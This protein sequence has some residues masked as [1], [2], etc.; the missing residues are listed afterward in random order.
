M[1]RIPIEHF[2]SDKQKVVETIDSFIELGENYI[3]YYVHAY[4]RQWNEEMSMLD[5]EPKYINDNDVFFKNAFVGC[6]VYTAFS[7]DDWYVFSIFFI[8]GESF[9]FRFKKESEARKA[10]NQIFEWANILVEA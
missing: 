4:I 8:N 10:M 5:E 6:R 9:W 7:N 3:R 1:I 2:D